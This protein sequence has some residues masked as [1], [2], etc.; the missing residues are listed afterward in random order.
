M[1][2]NH[3]P[4]IVTDGLVF[5]Y[6]MGNSQKSWKGQPTTNLYT[7]GNFALG[8][9]HPVNGG[10]AVVSDP[11]GPSQARNVIKF[12]PSAGNQYHG[13]DITVTVSTVYSLQMEV[14]VSADFNGTNVQMYPEQAGG[15][16]NV[17]YDLTKKGTWQTLKFNG[18]A[19]STT[20]LRM[21]AYVLSSFTTGFVLAT[22]IQV[23][24]NSF[25]TPFVNGTRS[26]TQALID[27]TGNN[28][29][30]A[31]SL[32]YANDGTFSFNGSNNYTSIPVSST[33]NF[34]SVFTLETWLNPNTY[35]G[36][37]II[38]G[39]GSYY[40]T[41]NNLYQLS[42][43]CYG[44]SPAGYH[45]TTETL[46]K[47][48]WNHI[49]A[50]WSTTEVSLYINGEFKKSVSTTGTPNSVNTQVWIGS[51]NNG[52]ARP[53][54]GRISSAKIYNRA[55][56][57]AEVK[58][59]FNAYKERFFGYQKL[60][61]TGSSNVT[62]TNNGTE[63]VTMFKTASNNAWDSHVYSAEAFTAPCTI[64]F[65]KNAGATDNGVSY[66]MIGWN[67][68]PTTD[69]SHSSLDWA[70]YPYM[71]NMY[72]VYH[73]GTQ[74]LA[75]GTWDPNKRFYIVYDTDGYIR[76]YNGSTLL[77]SVNKGTGQ[78]V[79]VDT[80]FYSVNA[81]YGGFTGVKVSRKSWNGTSYV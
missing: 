21:L 24:Q 77:Y 1:A 35:I 49:C 28:T 34:S 68:D 3:S 79:Y 51:E 71:S 20:N 56:S 30:T 52:T 27:L 50:A 37:I 73:N 19:A 78:T 2:L 64:E 16:A 32:T 63:E 76:H 57:A 55:L 53:F 15:G 43:Y 9:T 25:C 72:S 81:T 70:S 48:S 59:N 75:S 46:T 66:A 7:D 18:K 60:T 23:E 45:T 4:K 36:D 80:A 14:Y 69:Q 22:N 67:A 11:T 44:K 29:I 54:N 74:V 61:Y 39:Q 65:T 40:L 12:S 47:D 13:R 31:S 33:L 5:A 58:Q 17:A 41:M 38:L 8:T 26:N 42:V 6:D 10:G 62:I